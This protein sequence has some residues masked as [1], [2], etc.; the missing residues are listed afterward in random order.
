MSISNIFIADQGLQDSASFPPSIVLVYAKPVFNAHSVH[1]DCF[2]AVQ[3]G[4]Q[5]DFYNLK[6]KY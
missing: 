2:S 6:E 5:L 3:K 4:N 1:S